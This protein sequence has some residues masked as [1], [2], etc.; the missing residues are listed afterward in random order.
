MNMEASSYQE[1]NISGYQSKDISTGHNSR[2]GL[3]QLSF[4]TVYCAKTSQT[5]VWYWFLLRWWSWCAIQKY[6]AIATLQNT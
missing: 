1:D 6:R 5:E 2:A 4:D 3:L